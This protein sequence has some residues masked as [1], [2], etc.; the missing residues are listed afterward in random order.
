MSDI[1]KKILPVQ[2]TLG[3]ILNT[4]THP[5][6]EGQFLYA[7]N[8]KLSFFDKGGKRF[9]KI[10]TNSS[11]IESTQEEILETDFN[12]LR[13]S[14]N[15][16]KTEDGLSML[17]TDAS[18]NTS[19]IIQGSGNYLVS[20]E[21]INNWN[22][23]YNSIG[24]LTEALDGKVDEVDGTLINPTIGT[25][26]TT[27][28]ISDT[29]DS[30]LFTNDGTITL[31]KTTVPKTIAFTDSLPNVGGLNTNNNSTLP[32]PT[33]PES[34]TGSINLHRISKTGTYSD[35]IGKPEVYTKTEVDNALALKL[36]T[37]LKG[38]INGLAELDANGRVPSS[39]LPSYVDDVLEFTSIAN[40]PVTGET[41][42][43]YI[44]QDTNKTYRWSGSGYSE[45]SASLALGETSSTAYRGDKGKIAYDHSQITGANPHGTTK[46]QITGLKTTD[47]P[48]FNGLTVGNTGGN[49]WT[50]DD[51][52][53]QKL[54]FKLGNAIISLDGAHQIAKT[55]AFAEDVQAA[56]TLT[57][58]R[59]VI[60]DGTGKLSVSNTTSSQVGYLSDVTSNIQAQI[61]NIIATQYA[62]IED[63]TGL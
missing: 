10:T 34:F 22:E 48:I 47:S 8:E 53:S 52:V 42:K 26:S 6:I 55:I 63:L 5:I 25:G 11:E 16:F 20:L 57:A 1:N 35:L 41:G 50:I 46:E 24:G 13:G 49:T 60:S 21:D 14:L 12:K 19:E 29:T 7:Y 58:N 56:I 23:A 37:S 27:W 62:V 36:N 28:T 15:I 43:I 39:Q 17:Y 30:L 44:A 9:L 54:T 32:V 3:N 31:P 38:A 61:N 33:T 18:G 40:F 51:L 45:I 59:A 2:D 4:S